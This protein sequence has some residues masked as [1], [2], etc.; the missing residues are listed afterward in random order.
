VEIPARGAAARPGQGVRQ[1]RFQG[2][3]IDQ[4]CVRLGNLIGIEPRFPEED[5]HSLGRAFG[6]QSFHR[7][8]EFHAGVAAPLAR[9]ACHIQVPPLYGDGLHRSP[10]IML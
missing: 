8:H 3:A 7:P 9:R 4:D 1:D 6:L 5:L 2:D 10:A